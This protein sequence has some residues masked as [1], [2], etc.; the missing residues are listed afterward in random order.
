M[1]DRLGKLRSQLAQKGLNAIIVSQA[2]NRRYLSGFTGSAGFLLISQEK[3]IFATDFRY[4]EQAQ[5]Q[6]SGFEI[7]KI[8]GEIQKWFPRPELH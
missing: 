4:V 3:A 2:E 1:T 6:T 7:V 5:S 8:E